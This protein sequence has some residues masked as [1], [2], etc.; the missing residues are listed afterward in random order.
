MELRQDS[1]KIK[2][3]AKERCATKEHAKL[4]EKLACDK[5]PLR[6]LSEIK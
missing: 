3:V 6:V 4:G 2:Q 5:E 1:A